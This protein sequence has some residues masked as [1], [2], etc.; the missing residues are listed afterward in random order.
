MTHLR[1]FTAAAAFAV[2]LMGAVP[3]YASAPATPAAAAAP[4]GS[5]VFGIM[6]LDG[7]LRKSAAGED[8]LKT[9]NAKRKEFEAQISKEEVA[10][11]KQKD[12]IIQ[13]RDKMTE[14]D[15]E[16]QR[17][18]FEKKAAEGFKLVQERKQMLDYAFNQSMTKLREEAL[19]IT[20][21]IARG[22]NLD[23]VFSDDSVILAERGYDISEEVLAR[24]NKDVKKIPVNF[25][26]PKK[27]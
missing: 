18:D 16:K 13:K 17:K 21:E 3:S 9:V 1:T 20:A 2:L 14:A 8:I 12:D 19:K 26:V 11:K 7:V 22:R 24:L 6:D 15:F 27:K 10:L 23:V 5:I 4:A 25:T